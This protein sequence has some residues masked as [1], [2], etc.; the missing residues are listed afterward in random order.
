MRTL[1]DNIYL[2]CHQEKPTEHKTMKKFRKQDSEKYFEEKKPVRLIDTQEYMEM[3]RALLEDGQEVSMIVTG[4]SMRPFLKHGRDKICMKKT[5]RKLRKG[6]IVFYRR[7]NG[8]YVMHRILKCGDQS[9]TLLGDGQIVPESGIRQE[10]IFARITKVQVRGKWIGP[11]NF[12]WRFFEHIWIRFCGIRKLGFSF[13]SKVQ[14]LKKSSKEIH[15]ETVRAAG[16]WKDGTFQ[17]I[18]DDW[19]WIL[20]YSVRYRW[21]IF[22]YTFLG[23]VSTSLGLLSS[24]AGKYLI[25]I[26][27]GYQMNK[28]GMIFGVMAGSFAV[29]LILNGGISRIMVKLNTNISNDIRADLFEQ[30][31]DVSWLELSKYQNGDMLSRFNQDIETVGSNA[32]SWLPAVVIAFYHFLATFLVLFYY[33][34]VMAGIALGSAPFVVLMSQFMMKKQR[35]CQKKVREMS[36]R[37]MTFE[38]ET[39]YNMDMIKSLGISLHCSTCLKKL[40]E[41][42]KKITLDYNLFSIKTKAVLSV[43]GMAIQFTAFGYCLFRLWTHAITYGTMTLFLQQRN[44]LS[45]AFQNLVS[46]IPSFLNSSVSAHRLRE[47]TEL[48]KEIHSMQNQKDL[49]L[50][51]GGL[52]VRLENVTFSYIKEKQVFRESDFCACPGEIVALVG[53]SGEGKTTLLR[54][55]LG[56]IE[57]DTGKAILKAQD[58]TEQKLNADTRVCFSY[59]PQGNTLLAGSIAENLSIAKEGASREE[60]KTALEMACAWEFV[61][62]LPEGL[63]TKLGERGKGLSEGQSQRIAIA[64]ALLRNAP[65][66]L[67]DE[68]TSALDEETEKKLLKNILKKA[69]EKTCIVTTHRPGVLRLC[70]RV[71]RV[72]DGKIAEQKQDFSGQSDCR[73]V[74]H[75]NFSG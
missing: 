72:E 57:P 32:V 59:V 71:Y 29:S 14:N 2:I 26:V 61:K 49:F 33:D 20:H 44:S 51:K 7:E 18:F 17:E 12:R 9:Y 35:D 66:I 41:Q 36:S 19:K 31:L 48:P 13:S 58:G 24:I 5:D 8:Q 62:K 63:E 39:F 23:T 10:Q 60:M 50:T 42:Y 53:T 70:R 16:K 22:F 34:K 65:V 55:I 30:I 47:L 3:I 64:R 75:R 28:A 52:E 37:M 54:L 56:L 43:V 21:T 45:G 38:A 68:A 4:N 25:D 15:N 27:T 73:T 40:Q 67:L 6:D 11:E 46:I 69:P 74:R 1:S